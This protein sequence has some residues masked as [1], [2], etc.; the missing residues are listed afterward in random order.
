MK[1]LIFVTLCLILISSSAF[2]ATTITANLSSKST[3]GLSVY[4]DDTTASSSTALI[5]KTS[6]GVGVSMASSELGYALSTQ[7]MMGSKMY[8]SSFDSTSLYAEDVATIGT[9][10]LQ[11]TVSDTSQFSDW[12]AL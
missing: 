12:G 10:Q 5:G 9:V 6:T 11:V 3:T 2:A 1:K 8:A 7:H 4:G